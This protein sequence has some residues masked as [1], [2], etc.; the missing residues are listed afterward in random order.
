MEQISDSRGPRR[1]A[2]IREVTGRDAIGGQRGLPKLTSLAIDLPDGTTRSGSLQSFDPDAEGVWLIGVCAI[3]AGTFTLC[4]ICLERIADSREHVPPQAF[5]GQ[6]MTN[7]CTPCNNRFGSRIE[8]KLQDWFDGVLQFR[9][10]PQDGHQ[11]VSGR[12]HALGGTR[13]GEHGGLITPERGSSLHNTLGPAFDVR[14]TAKV[15]IRGPK[16]NVVQLGIMKSAYLAAVLHLGGVPTTPSA[17]EI[18]QEL[19]AAMEKPRGSAPLT[20]P[21]T[22]AL[23]FNRTHQP[24]SG[25]PL[26]LMREQHDD[27]RFYISLAGTIVVEWP[28]PDAP[29]G[30]AVPWPRR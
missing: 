28:F 7:T 3:H 22:D 24:P 17:Q 5:G 19:L 1:Q 4:P 2:A 30:S 27:S 12:V 23:R 6:V 10:H 29:P 15:T 8:S 20:Y 25:I 18:R 26:A 11:G 13:E 16:R 14:S 21:R 9:L